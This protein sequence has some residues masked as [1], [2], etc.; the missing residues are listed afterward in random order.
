MKQTKICQNVLSFVKLILWT[1]KRQCRQLGRKKFEQRLINL[2]SMS[3]IYGEKKLDKTFFTTNWSNQQT[4]SSTD[5]G[6]DKISSKWHTKVAQ[7]PMMKKRTFLKKSSQN[8]LGHV[9]SSC[10]KFADCFLTKKNRYFSVHFP[11]IIKKT[12][13]NFV[14]TKLCPQNDPSDS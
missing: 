13:K 6:T 5:I 4:E 9:V 11:K 12:N 8:L 14:K 1:R 7:C 10:D 3:V 2:R